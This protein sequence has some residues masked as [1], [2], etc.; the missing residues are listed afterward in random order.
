[1]KEEHMEELVATGLFSGS[2]LS[3]L[4]EQDETDGVTYIAQYYCDSLDD[5]YD[6]VK[7]HAPTIREKG[8]KKFGDQMIA[9][10]TIMEV[11]G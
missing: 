2:R 6:Y 9:F 3:H 11:E 10:R 1:M 8:L 4:L 7:D 5:Y